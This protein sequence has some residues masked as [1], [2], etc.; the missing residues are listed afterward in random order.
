VIAP[1]VYNLQQ[2]W[3]HGAQVDRDFRDI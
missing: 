1:I 3:P 2:V